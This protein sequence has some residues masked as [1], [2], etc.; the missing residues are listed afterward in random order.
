MLF[1]KAR[2]NIF[3]DLD[4]NQIQIRG[5][6][7]S[8]AKMKISPCQVPVFLFHRR[9]LHFE[10]KMHVYMCQLSDHMMVFNIPLPARS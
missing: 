1:E 5:G 10:T 8:N 4:D 2:F 3:E 9:Y 6:S 7:Y